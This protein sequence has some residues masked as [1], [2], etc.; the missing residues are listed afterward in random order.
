MTN[1]LQEIK[2]SIEKLQQRI[3]DI[4]NDNKEDEDWIERGVSYYSINEDG[5]IITDFIDYGPG[6]FSRFFIGNIFKTED[7][8]LFKLEKLKVIQE[9]KQMA[10]PLRTGRNNYL[11]QY[12]SMHDRLIS[13]L[14]TERVVAYGDFY[15]YD[16]SE[17]YKAI[18]RI[19]EGRIKK[20]LFGVVTE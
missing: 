2:D 19:G 11:I 7:E 15:F 20:Y 6:D 18:D 5:L 1:E 9:L 12:D 14:Y 13:V 17:L 8:A 10:G 3:R 4:E 16:E